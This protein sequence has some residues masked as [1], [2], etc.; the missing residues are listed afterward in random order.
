MLEVPN[1]RIEDSKYEYYRKQ[2]DAKY[3]IFVAIA[4]QSLMTK[5]ILK[6]YHKGLVPEED[7]IKALYALNE[8]VHIFQKEFI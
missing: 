5:R 7:A 3:Y 1:S 4:K 2:S 8:L 6:L